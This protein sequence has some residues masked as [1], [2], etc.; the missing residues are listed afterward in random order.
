MKKTVLVLALI[1]II[2]GQLT[3]LAAFHT[4]NAEGTSETNA[5]ITVTKMSYVNARITLTILPLVNND[6]ENV[7]IVFPNGTSVNLTTSTEGKPPQVYTETFIF[8]RTGDSLGLT[9]GGI[10]SGY[11]SVS[12]TSKQPLAVTTNFDVNNT[13]N[14]RMHSSENIDAYTFIINGGARI[15]VNGYG[16]GL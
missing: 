4:A 10:G 16:V 6:A 7:E 5:V 14:Y 11:N 12:L 13:Q 9:G 3:V 8:S 1:L 2:A 15:S